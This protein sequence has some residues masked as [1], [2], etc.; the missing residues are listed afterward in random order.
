MKGHVLVTTRYS[1][2]NDL[3]PAE[4]V[5]LGDDMVMSR[6]RVE[7][8]MVSGPRCQPLFQVLF[9]IC[10]AAVGSKGEL[11]S[12]SGSVFVSQHPAEC[13]AL[14]E[15]YTD[16]GPSGQGLFPLFLLFSPS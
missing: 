16:V 10:F 2:F 13:S 9:E 8:Y 14:E 3:S 15:D 1:I 7:K 11:Q 4:P 12:R 6:S 5:S